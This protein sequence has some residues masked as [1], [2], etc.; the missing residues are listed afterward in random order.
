MSHYCYMVYLINPFSLDDPPRLFIRSPGSST[1]PASLGDI[2]TERGTIVSYHLNELAAF[3][4]GSDGFGDSGLIDLEQVARLLWGRPFDGKKG[5]APWVVWSLINSTL[6]HSA[7]ISI[8][9]DYVYLKKTGISPETLEQAIDAFSTSLEALW[10]ILRQRLK[11]RGEAERYFQVEKP[12]NELFLRCQM[13]GI[14]IDR[15]S[16]LRRLDVVDRETR[17]AARALRDRWHVRDPFDLDDVRRALRQAGLGALAE[18]SESVFDSLLDLHAEHADLARHLKAY[19]NARRDKATLLQ[20]GGVIAERA[21]PIYNTLATVTGRIFAESPLLQHLKRSHRDVIGADRGKTLLYPDFSQFEP[22]IM[23]DDSCDPQLLEDFN[24]GDLYTALSTCLFGDASHRSSAKI[25][26]LSFC[27]GM[28][29]DG[30]TRHATEATGASADRIATALRSFFE[31]YVRLSQWANG[32][33]RTLVAEGRIGT[34]LGNFRYRDQLDGDLTPREQR[35]VVSQRIQGTA[36]LVFKRVILR[37]ARELPD[38]DIL[39]PMHDAL[40]LQVPVD[41]VSETRDLVQDIFVGEFQHECRRLRPRVTFES[42][43]RC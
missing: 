12:I 10:V 3:F 40:L 19:R 37:I 24:S 27:Y 23:A 15:D 2:Q 9:Y 41:G 20:I 16:L 14:P 39:L 6:G 43:A 5:D 11:E 22:G 36:S 31:R 1:H 30:M 8:L 21:Y 32:L 34:R 42:F 13:R 38:A 17:H 18:A 7:E 33:E 35:W 29:L 25:L 26:F 4:S 28:T